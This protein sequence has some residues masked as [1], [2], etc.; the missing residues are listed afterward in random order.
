[1]ARSDCAPQACRFSRWWTFQATEAAH[2][3]PT[4]QGRARLSKDQVRSE[5]PGGGRSHIAGTTWLPFSCDRCCLGRRAC[6][7]RP[8][9]RRARR[10]ADAKR[11]K[12]PETRVGAWFLVRSLCA[13][14]QNWTRG[15]A[16]SPP[17]R[18]RHRLRRRASPHATHEGAARTP[19]SSDGPG[20]ACPG[21]QRHHS[22]RGT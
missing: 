2:A 22:P 1:M 5:Q 16:V 9:T 19:R 18:S 6:G 8:N 7:N 14:T 21:R 20:R 17:D 10:G 11:T 12:S 15:P 4:P 13:W 3:T